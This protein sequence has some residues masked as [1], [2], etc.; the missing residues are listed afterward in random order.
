[1][2][3]Q[4]YASP[5]Q[6]NSAEFKFWFDPVLTRR[7]FSFREEV[8][9]AC[10]QV[11]LNREG[12]TVALCYNGGLGSEVIA[13]ALH[14]HGI[15]FELYFL[16]LWGLNRPH[17]DQ[18]A[19]EFARE[20]GKNIKIFCLDREYFYEEHAPKTFLETGLAL[21]T[22]LA[23]TYLFDQIPEDQFIV[24]GEGDLSRF[25][26]WL[27]QS[28]GNEISRTSLPFS[29]RQIFYYL[30]NRTRERAG[31]FSFFSSTP[32]LIGAVVEDP[33]F[34]CAYPTSDT[35]ALVHA[36]FPEI[37]ERPRSTNWDGKAFKENF[38][39]R[40]HLERIAKK[41]KNPCLQR[42]PGSAVA[43]LRGIFMGEKN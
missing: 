20:I 33:L 27:N 31:E 8:D 19:G 3:G 34:H 15:P 9:R 18:W 17:F 10:Q 28:K 16:D 35:R 22:Y 30:W 21:P 2:G 23:I 41:S 5:V 4:S 29:P 7:P 12:K 39:V 36:A 38:W 1:M 25:G 26:S 14:R 11:D 24:V 32:G 43:D 37:R 40:N 6:V 42:K 13:R